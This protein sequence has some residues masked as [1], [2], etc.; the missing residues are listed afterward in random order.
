MRA[1]ELVVP[2]ARN[3]ECRRRPDAPPEQAKHVECPL[4]G[5]VHILDDHD[6][7]DP[8]RELAKER[9]RHLVRS[10]LTLHELAEL[11]ACQLCNVEER[12][13]WPRCEQ[14]V[15]RA[16]Q[17]ACRTCLLFAEMPQKKRLTDSCLSA[18]E[19][20]TAGSV[21]GDGSNPR[22]KCDKRVLALEERG[23][24]LSCAHRPDLRPPRPNGSPSNAV[25][26]GVSEAQ[27]EPR[28]RRVAPGLPGRDLVR[29]VT[30]GPARAAA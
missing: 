19:S 17:E 24:T 3:H 11:A 7:R 28:E 1:V 16:P 12:T 4:V 30:S 21:V 15:A 18:Y 22:R 20:E 5:P 26:Q 14:R 27:S 25:N 10:R 2:I 29:L 23:R 6:R 9:S 13:E 8:G